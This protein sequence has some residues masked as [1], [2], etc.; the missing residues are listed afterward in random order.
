M[1]ATIVLALAAL[2]LPLAFVSPLIGLCWYSVLAYMRPHEWAYG[3]GHISFGL[4]TAVALLAGMAARGKFQLFRGS[5]VTYTLLVL[6]FWYA[7]TAHTAIDPLLAKSMGLSHISKIFL[8]CLVTTA[9]CEDRK[10]IKWVLLAIVGGLS[11]HGIKMGIYGIAHPGTQITAP[12]GGM[13]SGNNE[14][15]IALN[16]ALPFCVYFALQAKTMSRRWVWWITS[17]LT[18]IAVIFSYSRGGFLGTVAAA[19]VML[20]NTRARLLMLTVVAPLVVTAFLTFA[21]DSYVERIGNINVARKTDQSALR[22]LQAWGS[23][24]TIT[25]ARP[26]VG[27]GPRNFPDNFR[28]FPHDHD[29]PRM[30]IHNTYLEI[31]SSTGIPGL[32]LYLLFIGAAWRSCARVR[33]DALARADERLV[34]YVHTSQA[35]QASITGFLVSSTFGSLMHFDLLYHMCAISACL[36][37]AYRKEIAVLDTA[38]AYVRLETYEL[39]TEDQMPD[40]EFGLVVEEV[41]D[42][43]D[44][45]SVSIGTAAGQDAAARDGVVTAA[46]DAANAMRPPERPWNQGEG[47]RKR[48]LTARWLRER[49]RGQTAPADDGMT[50]YGVTCPGD[51]DEGEPGAPTGSETYLGAFDLGTAESRPG[52]E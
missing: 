19:C 11:F 31:S 49:A 8:I 15:A 13:I 40:V 20:W 48:G 10:S 5:P 41:H 29:M 22:R 9:L 21:P 30:E 43:S 34:W 44:G 52:D 24:W 16:I 47:P 27:I 38:D 45:V 35:L 3:I 33:R 6:W 7:I 28:R 23:A 36:P 37:F 46:A 12:I 51:S 26:I 2:A 50:H 4:Y 25:K 14:N 32:L 1:R 39:P 18:L 17:V 42:V